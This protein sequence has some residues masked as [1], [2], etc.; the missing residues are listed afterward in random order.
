MAIIIALAVFARA[1]GA[2]VTVS[3]YPEPVD[4]TL[5]VEAP[6]EVPV[7]PHQRQKIATIRHDS[8]VMGT[9]SCE[10]EI[11]KYDWDFRIVRA[12][13]LAESKGNTNAHNF[14]HQTKDDSWGCMQINLY[15]N[16]AKSR[17]PAEQLV[18][19]ELNV[20]HAYKMYQSS[21]LSPWSAYKTGK[22]LEFLQ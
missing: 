11:A 3:E 9:G 12:V 8:V 15:G 19:A 20:A 22:Y 17:P 2:A 21:G 6:I 18:V 7:E 16:L 10:V 14:S 5:S 4:R 1:E 13:M